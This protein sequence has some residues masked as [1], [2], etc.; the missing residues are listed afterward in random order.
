MLGTLILDYDGDVQ[1]TNF[2]GDTPD[3]DKLSSLIMNLLQSINY[4]M[5]KSNIDGLKTTSVVLES[6][7]TYLVY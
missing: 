7:A 4:T 1:D 5:L 6:N 3:V 2:E